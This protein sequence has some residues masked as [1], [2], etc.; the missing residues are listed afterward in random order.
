MAAS[1]D[2]TILEEQELAV[3]LDR[4]PGWSKQGKAIVRRW[5]FDNFQQITGFMKHLAATIEATNHHPD[6]I[7]D[8]TTRSVTI[9]V[10]THSV[11]GKITRADVEF[12]R[13]LNAF[14]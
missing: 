8:T 6:A 1:E 10:V 3:E 14:D 5:L 11:G 4:L 7:L 9:T 13:Q 12:A 2:K